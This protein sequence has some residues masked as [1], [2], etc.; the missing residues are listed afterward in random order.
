MTGGTVTGGTVLEASSSL[1]KSIRPPEA[2][3]PLRLVTGSTEIFN[4][5]M[6][7]VYVHVGWRSHN[8]ASAPLMTGVAIDVPLLVI[9]PPPRAVLRMLSPGAAIRTLCGP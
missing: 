9:Y 1:P 6:I 8:S 5:A 2:T 3:F 7:C 4:F